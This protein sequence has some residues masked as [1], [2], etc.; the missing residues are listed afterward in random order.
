MFVKK[1]KMLLPRKVITGNLLL[2][3]LSWLIPFTVSLLFFRRGQLTVSHAMFKSLMMI[4]GTTSGCY[5]LLRY[6][7]LIDG[8]YFTNGIVVGIC[9]LMINLVLDVLILIPMMKTTFA[10]Y[11]TSIGISYLSI[12]AISTAMGYLLSLKVK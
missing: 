1:K 4:V 3:L 12:P 11:F 8:R 10:D 7:R 2:G 5:L 6:F 9:W